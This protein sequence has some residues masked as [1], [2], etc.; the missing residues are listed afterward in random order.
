MYNELAIKTPIGDFSAFLQLGFYE[1]ITCSRFHN[2]NYIEVHLVLDGSSTF[3]IEDKQYEI[4]SGQMLI[5]P[6]KSLHACMRQD[7]STMRT[8]FQMDCAPKNDISHPEVISVEEGT[9][10][11]FFDEIKL[12]RENNDYALI[13]AFISLFC[14]R[15]CSDE[16][17]ESKKVINHGFAIHEFFLNRYNEDVTLSDLAAMLRLSERQTERLVLEYMGQN[18]RR[19]LTSTR[20]MIAKQL[21]RSSNMSLSEIA[22]YV[23]YHSYAG[24]WKAMKKFDEG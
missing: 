2:H 15:F 17:L 21:L 13:A 23:G 8:A 19:T 5:I 12:C 16:Y 7:E 24:F 20:V 18:F 14:C 3:V 22:E 6:K 1:N 9:L 11:R 10:R 4:K